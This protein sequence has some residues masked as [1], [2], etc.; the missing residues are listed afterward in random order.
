MNMVFRGRTFE[1]TSASN[2]VEDSESLE[3]RDPHQG[4][5]PLVAAVTQFGSYG[6]VPL[7][8]ILFQEMD[9]ETVE[10]VISYSRQRM[11]ANIVD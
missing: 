8:L 11:G 10:E 9:L 4:G 3:F 5:A 6:S 7:Y 1:V 2:I